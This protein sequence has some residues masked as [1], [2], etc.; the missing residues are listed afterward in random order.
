MKDAKKLERATDGWYFDPQKNIAHIKVKEQKAN[1]SFSTV[2]LRDA[3][4]Y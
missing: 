3:K 1:S 2:I 4:G